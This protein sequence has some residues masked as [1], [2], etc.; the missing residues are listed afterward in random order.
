VTGILEKEIAAKCYKSS[1]VVKPPAKLVDLSVSYASEFIKIVTAEAVSCQKASMKVENVDSERARIQRMK[2]EH[3]FK[4]L[5]EL[6]YPS[7]AKAAKKRNQS[8]KRRATKFLAENSTKL[9]SKDRRILSSA[10]GSEKRDL[11]SKKKRKRDKDALKGDLNEL[12]DEQELLL[13]RSKEKLMTYSS[14]G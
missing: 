11:L 2:V 9:L 4:A 13:Q 12:A 6:G 1:K 14:K 10:S 3:V 5:E 7:I 8:R